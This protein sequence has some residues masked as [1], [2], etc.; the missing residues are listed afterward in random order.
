MKLQSGLFITAML[1]GPAA[2]ASDIG[3]EVVPPVCVYDDFGAVSPGY[4]AACSQPFQI[5]N[6]SGGTANLTTNNG[7]AAWLLDE[8][9]GGDNLTLQFTGTFGVVD[10][11]HPD[12]GR[13]S[14]PTDSNH[15]FARWFSVT[16]KNTGLHPWAGFSFELRST[17]DLDSDD[18]DTVGFGEIRNY[19]TLYG[20]PS[21]PNFTGANF[22]DPDFEAFTRDILI[23][24]DGW[25]A[26]QQS[27]NFQ[28]LISSNTVE[29]FY[30]IQQPLIIPEPGS[31]LAAAS[32]LA[33]L[34]LAKRF[35]G[36]RKKTTAAV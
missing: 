27:A 7:T 16:V 33:A 26:P 6:R 11:V 17:L 2:T 28:F 22:K 15:V 18:D 32:G 9:V 3:G 35:S 29:D 10:P 31:V 20:P 8:T 30:L 12:A 25:I 5:S 13:R 34:L 19:F 4:P 14:N 21:S 1:F 36:K 23:F 24:R